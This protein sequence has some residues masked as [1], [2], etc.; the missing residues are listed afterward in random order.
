MST[1]VLNI[2][3]SVL[4][5]KFL[6]LTYTQP[7]FSQPDLSSTASQ[8]PFLFCY[9]PF[10]PIKHFLIENKKLSCRTEAARCFVP[11]KKFVSHSRSFKVIRNLNT[12]TSVTSYPLW[13]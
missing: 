3:F 11:L 10:S 8:Y 13:T 1:N 12:T 7:T 5:T 6:F 4:P 2:N 9:H